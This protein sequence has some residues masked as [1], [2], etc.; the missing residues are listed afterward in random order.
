MTHQTVSRMRRQQL[1]I[2]F[3]ACFTLALLSP[4]VQASNLYQ[5]ERAGD[6]AILAILDMATVP[7]IATDVLSLEFTAIGAPVFGFAA[8]PYPGT[9]TSTFNSGFAPDGIGG[10]EQGTAAEGGVRSFDPPVSAVVPMT[11]E[12]LLGATTVAGNDRVE[13]RSSDPTMTLTV[14]GDWRQVP[15]PSTVAGLISLGAVGVVVWRRKKR[16]A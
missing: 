5:F 10:L 1:R 2:A 14:Q 9:F 12:L 11:T 6:G 13:L 15:E 7:G 8:G 16:K 3:I 4:A